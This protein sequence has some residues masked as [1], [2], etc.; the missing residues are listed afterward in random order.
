MAKIYLKKVK[1]EGTYCHDKYK[2]YCYF[3]EKSVCCKP[4]IS[5][6]ICGNFVNNI[7]KQGYIFLQTIKEENEDDKNT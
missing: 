2:N 6:Y 7:F 5:K 3:L 4:N 1:A